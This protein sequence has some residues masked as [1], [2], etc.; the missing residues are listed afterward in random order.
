MA[1]RAARSIVAS[2]GGGAMDIDFMKF[3]S[4]QRRISEAETRLRE[5]QRDS[6]KRLNATCERIETKL[7]AAVE[8]LDAKIDVLDAK[9]DAVEAK[10][11]AKIDAL[12]AK[13]DTKFARLEGKFDTFQMWM[14]GIVFAMITGFVGIFVTIMLTR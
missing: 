14:M 11:E 12:E 8:R 9:I 4:S 3:E 1:A 5:E 6:E 13:F 7:D 10:L 2:K